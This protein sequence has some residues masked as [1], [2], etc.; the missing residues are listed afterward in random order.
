M[1]KLWQERY[2]NARN[3]DGGLPSLPS[4]TWFLEAMLAAKSNGEVVS[5]QDMD[6]AYGCDWHLS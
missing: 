6:Y 2:A 1:E 4:Q 5:T 3:H